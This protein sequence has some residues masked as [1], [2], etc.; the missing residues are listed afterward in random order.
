MN[1]FHT[2]NKMKV[3]AHCFSFLIYVLAPAVVQT[4]DNA[5]HW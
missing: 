2:T 3:F 4:V 5:I 1:F